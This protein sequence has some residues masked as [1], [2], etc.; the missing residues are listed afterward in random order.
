MTWE[1]V[2]GAGADSARGYRRFAGE[3]EPGIG[4][5]A[6]SKRL[7]RAAA[8]ERRR[9]APETRPRMAGP[10]ETPPPSGGCSG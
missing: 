3:G 7:M 1:A 4:A 5:F 8:V 6:L 10:F 2:A 9:L